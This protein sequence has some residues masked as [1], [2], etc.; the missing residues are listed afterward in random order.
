VA[1]ALAVRT[2]D[3]GTGFVQEFGTQALSEEF[4]GEVVVSALDLAGHEEFEGG[5]VT[6]PGAG[7]LGVE[8]SLGPEGTV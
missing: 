8:G 4:G 2:E 6:F 7:P 5:V 1:A 3:C